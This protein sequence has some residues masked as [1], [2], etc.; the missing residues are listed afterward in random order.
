MGNVLVHLVLLPFR[1]SV[2]WLLLALLD[3]SSIGDDDDDDV[4][5]E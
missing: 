2:A 5:E 3:D 4:D 1:Q